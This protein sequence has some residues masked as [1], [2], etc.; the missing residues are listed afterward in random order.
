MHTFYVVLGGTGVLVHNSDGPASIPQ[1]D[2]QGLQ[3]VVNNLYKGIGNERLVG[4]GSAMAA[5]SAE[6]NG[7][8]NVEGRSH[9]KSAKDIQV[10]KSLVS[11]IDDALAGKY[12][13][14]SNYPG[15]GNC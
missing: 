1:V 12:T 6:V 11:A 14:A 2:N 7:H 9:V 4:D 15:L 5:A 3:S 13:G 10:A 8:A